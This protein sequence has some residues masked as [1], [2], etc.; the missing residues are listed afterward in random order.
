MKT[1]EDEIFIDRSPRL[2]EHI[3]CLLR[4][5]S[6]EYPEEFKSEL[7]FYDIDSE[8]VDFKPLERKLYERIKD[9]E[10]KLHKFIAKY[11]MMFNDITNNKLND[12]DTSRIIFQKIDKL[13]HIIDDTDKTLPI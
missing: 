7:D 5:P 9:L 10:I 1:R 6:Y 11:D 4:N 2:F 12:D 8:T 13:K 3:L